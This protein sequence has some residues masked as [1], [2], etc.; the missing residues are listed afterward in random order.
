[1]VV[2]NT[3]VHTRPST[4]SLDVLVVAANSRSL[5]ANRGDL[6]R[7]MLALGYRVAAVVPN[8]DYLPETEE[9]GIDLYPI[10][11]AR[12]A[13]NPLSDLGYLA[14]L[15]KLMRELKPKTVFSYSA[16]PVVYGSLA[17]KLAGVPGRFSMITGLGHA[18]TT[19][20][21]KTRIVRQVLSL[22]YR[23]GISACRKVFFQ[24][25]DDVAQLRELGVLRDASK[26]VRTNGSGV[27]TKRFQR[28]PIPEGA[29]LFLFIGRLLTEKGVAEFVEAASRVR[30]NWP[31]ARFVAVG[32]HDPGLPHSVAVEDLASWETEG[33]V[34]F[35]GGVKDVRPWLEQCSVFVLPSYREGTPRS[36]L[37]AMSV[38]RPIITTDAPGCRETVT[39]GV[40]G[41]LVPPQTTEPLARAMEK[42]LEQPELIS[43]MADSSRAI[44]EE[45]YEVKKVN[46]VIL[47]AM[48]L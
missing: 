42:L 43:T 16:K 27:D 32:P 35:V 30:S 34:E 24:N 11:M 23:A 9:L 15:V 37:E 25:P 26:V 39:D 40:N 5:I 47:G 33:V 3:Q 28:R 21:R 38:G 22:L 41:F 10:E 18:F 7:E 20:D 14:S 44:A 48:G 46:R 29:P 13:T 12:T 19:T 6:I 31:N 2:P 36:V 45:K 4:D 17:A 1:M 8:A